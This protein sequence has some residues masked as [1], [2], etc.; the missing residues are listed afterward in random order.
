M[1]CCSST[2]PTQKVFENSQVIDQAAERLASLLEQA[3]EYQEFARLASLINLDPDVKRI[4]LEIRRQQMMYTS[5]SEKSVETLQSELEMLPAMQAY[6]KAETALKELFRSV[7]QV[8]STAAKVEFA[9][10]ALNSA[11]G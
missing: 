7:D 4:L 8:I 3:P 11:C 9:P 5:T 1:D 10:N 2:K 6:H